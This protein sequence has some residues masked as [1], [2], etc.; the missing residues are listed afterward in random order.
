MQNTHYE[1][2]IDNCLIMN[3][4][5][6]AAKEIHVHVYNF[7]PFKPSPSK[8]K[9]VELLFKNIVRTANKTTL[10]NYKDQSVNVL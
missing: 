2:Q 1:T 7:I 3:D 8:L 9:L 4:I 10:L 6:P 5:P